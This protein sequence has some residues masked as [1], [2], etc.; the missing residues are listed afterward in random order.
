MTL[1]CVTNDLLSMRP[2]VQAG[3][4]LPYCTGT[5]RRDRSKLCQG[6]QPRPASHGLL[7]NT[8]YGRLD[9]AFTKWGPFA[10]IVAPLERVMTADTG[11]GQSAALGYIPIPKTHLDIDEVERY[12]DTFYDAHENISLWVSSQGGSRDAVI[13]TRLAERAF[14]AHPLED[15]PRL[16]DSIRCI[17]CA[18]WSLVVTP[19]VNYLDDLLVTCQNRACGLELDQTAYERAVALQAGEYDRVLS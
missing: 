1:A 2:C 18:H 3:A 16:A 8:C 14:R 12:L 13:F 10:D 9:R 19:P 15:K 4:H 5:A 17:K 11:G 7:C 6:C